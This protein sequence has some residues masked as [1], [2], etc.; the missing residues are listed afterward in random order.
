MGMVLP[1][2]NEKTLPW[3]RRYLLPGRFKC[4]SEITQCKH[5]WGCS[6][7]I[8][9][10]SQQGQQDCVNTPELAANWAEPPK[11]TQETD[12]SRLPYNMNCHTYTRNGKRLTYIKCKHQNTLEFRA[13]LL[14][15]R[16][17]PPQQKKRKRKKERK[18][19][20]EKKNHSSINAIWFPP[21]SLSGLI[22]ISKKVRSIT[23]AFLSS[24]ALNDCLQLWTLSCSCHLNGVVTRPLYQPPTFQRLVSGLSFILS[25]TLKS[26]QW[27]K[28]KKKYKKIRAKN[29]IK[30]TSSYKKIMFNSGI[31]WLH[32]LLADFAET[33]V[34]VPS[35]SCHLGTLNE[36]RR[37]RKGLTIKVKTKKSWTQWSQWEIC[38]WPC[39]KPSFQPGRTSSELTFISVLTAPLASSPSLNTIF[40]H[41]DKADHQKHST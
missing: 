40:K 33:R 26:N 18:K 23:E 22:L 29:I 5:A 27:V 30:Y 35:E 6:V 24:A 12:Y 15:K 2:I 20:R 34:P 39:R 14:T 19:K 9:G 31:I 36:N 7:S 25:I 32:N 13:S 28:T 21:A 37:V 8:D 10:V 3:E 41:Q 1:V 11:P 38:H 17:Q 4:Y 16:F